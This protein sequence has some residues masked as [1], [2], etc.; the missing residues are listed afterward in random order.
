MTI[1]PSLLNYTDILSRNEVREQIKTE[2][3]IFE[4]NK[5]SLSQK[6]GIYIYGNS[7]IGKTYFIKSI[8]KE[9]NYH[10]ISYNAGDVRN[11]RV[12]ENLTTTHTNDVSVI[13]ALRG[14]KQNIAVIMDEIDGM[15]SGDK[16]G[17]SAL[18]KL[19]RPKRTKKQKLEPYT[20]IPV[21]CIGNYHLDKKLNELMKVCNVFEI[22]TPT[23]VQIKELLR[24]TLPLPTSESASSSDP[25]TQISTNTCNITEETIDNMTAFL[26]GD[27]NKLKFLIKLYKKNNNIN[28]ELLSKVFKAKSYNED[29]KDI[30]YKLMNKLYKLHEHGLLMNETDRTIV[31][32]LW[33]ENVIDYLPNCVEATSINHDTTSLYKS[34]LNN[35]CFADYIDRVTFQKQIWQLNEMTSIIKTLH[36][37]KIYH[38]NKKQDI[39]K[40]N[41]IK[42]NTLKTNSTNKETGDIRFTKVLTKYST[43]YNNIL[44]IQRLCHQLGVDEKDLN[45]MFMY[46]QMKMKMLEG[47]DSKLAGNYL[48]Q[49][50]DMYS[51]YE[52]NKL[53]VE[54]MFRYIL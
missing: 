37:N 32:L 40:Q 43:E 22:P 6:R 17:I 52:I 47:I 21:I 3:S 13:S 11:K 44:Y 41:N 24:I 25:Q 5:Q 54:R 16:G 8:L 31:G 14:K 15:H 19:I 34:M 10:V 20:V 27:L 18:I 46:I 45:A 39:I 50:Y 9:M 35:I 30:T 33:H 51:T 42:K 53:D 28:N 48:Q 38:L 12:I 23:S 26:G 4:K 1:E 7:G 49:I 36:T 2:L 29:A